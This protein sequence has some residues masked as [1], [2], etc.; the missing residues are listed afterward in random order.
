MATIQDESGA[1]DVYL[2]LHANEL[3]DLHALGKCIR[4][5]LS[6]QLFNVQ[7]FGTS[8]FSISLQWHPSNGRALGSQEAEDVAAGKRD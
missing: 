4:W 6:L 7:K 8:P 1:A 3:C 2:L 5:T